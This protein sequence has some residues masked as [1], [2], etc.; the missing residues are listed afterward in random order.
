MSAE[1]ISFSDSLPPLGFLLPPKLDHPLDPK[2]G[3]I[4]KAVDGD[5]VGKVR[6]RQRHKCMLCG[7]AGNKGNPLVGHHNFAVDAARKLLEPGNQTLTDQ[8]ETSIK[9][10]RNLIALHQN[11][12]HPYVNNL[13]RARGLYVHQILTVLNVPLT[14][15]VGIPDVVFD[16]QD[17]LPLSQMPAPEGLVLFSPVYL[18]R[19]RLGQ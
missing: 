17:F 9:D 16:G 11:N 6:E 2:W 15:R 18:R 19:S 8:I 10:K 4:D 3:R 12:C 13:Q 1:Q 7:L 14:D 5:V